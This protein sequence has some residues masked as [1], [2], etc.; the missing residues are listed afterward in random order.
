MQNDFHKNINLGILEAQIIKSIY[1]RYDKD[2]E[3]PNIDEVIIVL[4]N[5]TYL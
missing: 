5:I 3:T 4:K 1:F 2:I